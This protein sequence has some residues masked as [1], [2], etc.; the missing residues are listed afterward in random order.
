[1]KNNLEQLGVG[2]KLRVIA[3]YLDRK[4]FGAPDKP[5]ITGVIK[6]DGLD[7]VCQYS[8]LDLTF[9]CE[10]EREEIDRAETYD[11]IACDC[12]VYEYFTRELDKDFGLCKPNN[13][14][15]VIAVMY[16]GIVYFIRVKDLNGLDIPK[17]IL[18]DRQLEVYYD[19]NISDNKPFWIVN[20]VGDIS[21]YDLI[22]ENKN[23]YCLV[24][25]HKV[26]LYNTVENCVKA[27]EY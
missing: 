21:G 6:E 23:I 16:E 13:I 15:V 18:K 26:R 4:D 8:Y 22:E 3:K 19:G 12:E 17:I 7:N 9:C 11:F 2:S 1:M 25:D 14:I 27:H 20:V 5:M 10:C 24:G